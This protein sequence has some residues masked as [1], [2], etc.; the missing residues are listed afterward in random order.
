M[1]I[2]QHTKKRLNLVCHLYRNLRK[3]NVNIFNK[4]ISEI[5]H[6]YLDSELKSV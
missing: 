3:G 1:S 5:P 6:F 4:E 2:I